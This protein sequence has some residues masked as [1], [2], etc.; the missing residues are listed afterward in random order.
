MGRN[1]N[2]RKRCSSIADIGAA[3]KYTKQ[4][5]NQSID[6]CR[7]I[8]IQNISLIVIAFFRVDRS[9]IRLIINNECRI[10]CWDFLLSAYNFCTMIFTEEPQDFAQNRG[11][12][13]CNNHERRHHRY[14]F[15]L[16]IDITFFVS[17][18]NRLDNSFDLVVRTY[19]NTDHIALSGHISD[20]FQTCFVSQNFFIDTGLSLAAKA[21]M[22]AGQ[23]NHNTI[24]CIVGLID[25]PDVMCRFTRLNISEHHAHSFTSYT[26]TRIGQSIHNLIRR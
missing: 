2:I 14:A 1:K 25:H 12:L 11:I 8:I 23:H 20:T 18:R 21:V 19:S 4:L 6:S 10:F 15:R 26:L 5:S 7:I 3:F 22:D 9:L 13:F 16:F 17:C 24:S